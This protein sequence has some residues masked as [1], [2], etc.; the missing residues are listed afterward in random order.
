VVAVDRDEPSLS[1]LVASLPGHG[2]VSWPADLSQ[3]SDVEDLP[4]RIAARV[5]P[6]NTLVHMAAVL[7]R[8]PV[9]SVRETD[10]DAQVDV[11]LKATFF[12]ARAVGKQMVMSSSGGTIILFASQ[13]WWTGGYDGSAVYAASKGGVV[14]LMRGLAREYGPARITVNAIAPGAID[15]P[16][17]RAG[18]S[19]NALAKILEATPLGR[20]GTPEEVAGAALFL[21]S[22][23]A[24]FITGTVLNVSGGWLLY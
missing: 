1:K 12:L 23:Q 9:D 24:R 15:T 20:L 13:S 17:L 4:S 3:L 22:S 6:L 2:H 14:S 16:M 21:A 11:N 10:W 18:L 19:D 7:L 8:L 5:G